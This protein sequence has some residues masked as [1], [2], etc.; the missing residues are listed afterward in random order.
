MPN[1]SHVF[2]VGEELLTFRFSLIHRPGGPR[3]WVT[4]LREEA[5]VTSFY[6]EKNDRGVWRLSDRY[7]TAPFWVYA[8]EPELVEA[9]CGHGV[10]DY[11]KSL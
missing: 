2:P 6:L 8:L 1:F 4:V 10:A 3:Y 9:I 11:P 5:Y 7:K